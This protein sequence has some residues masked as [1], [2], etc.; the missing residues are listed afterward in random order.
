VVS[1]DQYI[2]GVV[3]DEM[4]ASW[5][6]EAIKAQA[7]AARTYAAWSRDQHASRYYQIC[8]TTSCQVYGGVAGEDARSNAAVRATA[9]EI[10]TYAGKAA[11]TQF[12]SSS[13]GWTSPGSFPYLTAQAD[14][15]DDFAGN[16]VH[17]WSTTLNA[18]TLE[19]GYPSIG[20]LRR[21]VV[22]S[23]DGR[24]ESNGRVTGVVLEGTRSSVSLTGDRFR[25]VTGL[26]TTWF[27]VDPTPIISRWTAIG[28]D[29]SVV[30]AVASGEY[31]VSHG[32][33]Q[34]F[35]RG[36]IYQSAATGSRE[37]YGPVL[38]GYQD[39]GGPGS[40]L[41]LPITPVQSRQP[42]SR[43]KF[44]NGV[45]YANPDT[46]TV[47]V[48]GLIGER[49]RSVGGVGSDLGWPTRTNFATT[50]GERVNFEHGYITWSKSTNR[51]QL[52]VTG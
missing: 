36:R 22:V 21:V 15:Y 47:P 31:K 2:Y 41:G 35:A 37:L 20:T 45:V 39:A 51:T 49:Y 26:R 16:P 5:Q 28:G 7:V 48:I 50:G 3:P 18:A 25:S 17:D 34:N 4:P 6:P 32:A 46:G 42:G 10:L 8:D 44:Q 14:P 43:A 52:R 12:G 9:R 33:A 38:D 23:R 29:T 24:G 27:T 13:G 11:F 1:M 19:R 30:G 40:R